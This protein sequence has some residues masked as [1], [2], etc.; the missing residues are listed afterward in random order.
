MYKEGVD[1]EAAALLQVRIDYIYVYVFMC[2]YVCMYVY[3]YKEGVDD[4]AAA[5]LQVLAYTRYCHYQ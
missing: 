2:M 3:I 4:E 1:D 5:L